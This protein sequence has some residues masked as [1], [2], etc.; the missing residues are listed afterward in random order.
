MSSLDT[1]RSSDHSDEDSRE[2]S[3]LFDKSTS[4]HILGDDCEVIE[5]DSEVIDSSCFLTIPLPIKSLQQN[6]ASIKKEVN[7]EVSIE[8]ENSIEE[9]SNDG[10][11]EYR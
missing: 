5:G 7:S 6:Q 4:P 8:N 3:P 10:D 1:E 2:F 11:V 9:S